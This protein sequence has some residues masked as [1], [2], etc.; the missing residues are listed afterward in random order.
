V[1]QSTLAEQVVA[2]FFSL[3]DQAASCNNLVFVYSLAS[4]SDTFAKETAEV[5][6]ELVRASARQ[7][8][9]LSPST[10]IEIYNIV[11]QRIFAS[12]SSEAAEK[13]AEEYLQSFRAS[14]V[15]LP[16]GC[17]DATYSTAIAQSYP[18]H[19]ELFNLLTR[20]IASIPEFQRTRGAL[21][22]FADVVRYLWRHQDHA[23]AADP[24]PSPAVGAGRGDHQRP[25][26]AITATVD[27]VAD[28]G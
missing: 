9:V 22:L 11:R 20:K 19:P 16:D 27:A 21:R 4:A 28:W 13:A 10:D 23:H 8:R 26:L 7:E 14:R 12:I 2:F 6:Q 15:N 5:Q 3:M 1:G 25:D 24:C 17:K 18:F